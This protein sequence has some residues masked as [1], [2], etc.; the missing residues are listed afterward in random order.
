MTKTV[1]CYPTDLNEVPI[2]L[3]LVYRSVYDRNGL[4]A[5]SSSYYDVENR[6]DCPNTSQEVVLQSTLLVYSLGW[7]KKNYTRKEHS[8]VRIIPI[9][10]STPASEQDRGGKFLQHKLADS[11]FWSRTWPAPSGECSKYGPTAAVSSASQ[12]GVWGSVVSIRPQT[13]VRD[14]RVLR[15]PSL[16]IHSERAETERELS[17]CWSERAW[18]R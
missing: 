18:W 14:R 17:L 10:S 9:L 8:T 6:Q 5:I 16:V 11:L 1:G 13:S 2:S 7:H 3:C 4:V 12:R 15:V